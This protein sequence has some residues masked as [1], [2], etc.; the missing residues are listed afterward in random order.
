MSQHF[1]AP[2]GREEREE[3]R[4]F[5]ET[6]FRPM[7]AGQKIEVRWKPSGVDGPM[8]RRFFGTLQEALHAALEL[9][10][11]HDVYVGAAPAGAR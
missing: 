2:H 3:T 6:L 5:L 4:G 11:A 1:D 7:R 10:E 8:R 9:G